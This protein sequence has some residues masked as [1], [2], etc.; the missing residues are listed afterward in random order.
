MPLKINHNN[1]I[2]KSI[3]IYR[4]TTIFTHLNKTNI[5]KCLKIKVNKL[6]S[7]NKPLKNIYKAWYSCYTGL[8]FCPEMKKPYICLKYNIM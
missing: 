1:L 2:F 6:S 4:M 5:L 7:G 8:L 3:L